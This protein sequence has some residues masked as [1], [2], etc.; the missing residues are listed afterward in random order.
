M[1]LTEK[2]LWN[3]LCQ[4][5]QGGWEW[6]DEGSCGLMMKEESTGREN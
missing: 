5:T 2:K 4:W 3:T 1:N 6:K